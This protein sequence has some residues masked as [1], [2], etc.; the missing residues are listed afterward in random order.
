MQKGKTNFI[1]NILLVLVVGTLVYFAFFAE[2]KSVENNTKVS[3]QEESKTTISAETKKISEDQ[4]DL[5]YTIDI[6]YPVFSG[7]DPSSLKKINADI[8]KN[9]ESIVS[10]FKEDSLSMPNYQDSEKSTLAANY[11]FNIP[12]HGIV[13]ILFSVAKYSTGAAHPNSLVISLNYNIASGEF[14]DLKSIFNTPNYLS[15]LRDTVRPILKEKLSKDKS[16]LDWMKNGT[17]AILENYTNFVIRD[18]NLV[19]LFNPYQVGP[20]ALGVVEASIP[21][22]KFSEQLNTEVIN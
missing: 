5:P 20:Y 2:N 4:K 13:S 7:I 15:L 1:R 21:I 16:S 18:D 8:L 11:S 9:A 14:V 19:I 10:D 22:I 3:L 12:T 6:S 17:E